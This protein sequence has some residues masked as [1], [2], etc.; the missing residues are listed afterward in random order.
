MKINLVYLLTA[1]QL[2]IW[3]KKRRFS[4]EEVSSYTYTA[5]TQ[6]QMSFETTFADQ[7]RAYKKIGCESWLFMI[8]WIIENGLDQHCPAE[9]FELEKR[10]Q[11]GNQKLM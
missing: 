3:I 11:N 8:L 4:T 9:F 7:M 6:Q 2:Q 5:T 1:I 10:E